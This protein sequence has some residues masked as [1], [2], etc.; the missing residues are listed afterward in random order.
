MLNSSI[1]RCRSASCQYLLPSVAHHFLKLGT[2]IR[3]PH[4]H[5][6]GRFIGL[7]DH[8]KCCL[9]LLGQ[10]YGFFEREI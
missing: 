4:H 9:V 7:V 6:C 5:V 10:I 3:R 8:A 1:K 2:R